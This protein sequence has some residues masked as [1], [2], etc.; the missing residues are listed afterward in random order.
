MSVI[1]AMLWRG[2]KQSDIAAY[3]G[4]N[5]GRIA[6]IHTGQKYQH[7]QG[8]GPYDLPPP[9][10]YPVLDFLSLLQRAIKKH[11]EEAVRQHLLN[12]LDF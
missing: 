8:A 1:K 2:D 6:E 12:L 9:G 5:G 10:P 3:F 11:G 7:V 4:V